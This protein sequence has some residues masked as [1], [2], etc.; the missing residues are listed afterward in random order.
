MDKATAIMDLISAYDAYADV[1]ELNVSA[2]ADAPATTL[3]CAIAVSKASSTWCAASV[4]AVSGA[5]YEL[6]C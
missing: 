3:P 2:A 6:T 1:S 5:T 4:S